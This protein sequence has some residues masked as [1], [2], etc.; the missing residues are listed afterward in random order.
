MQSEIDNDSEIEAQQLQEVLKAV[1]D[2][3]RSDPIRLE[4]YRK[5]KA[6]FLKRR[7]YINMGG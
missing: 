4:A 1:G 6:N 7:Y 5:F 3:L 2:K